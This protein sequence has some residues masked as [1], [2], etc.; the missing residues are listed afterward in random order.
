MTRKDFEEDA[1]KYL[2]PALRQYRHN[3]DVQTE[4]Q[5]VHGFEYEE[6]IKLMADLIEENERLNSLLQ[7]LHD[8]TERLIKALQD[9]VA[10][11]DRKHD[12][13]DAAKA[14]IAKALGEQ[15]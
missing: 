6:T 1:K 11:S 7:T 13:W 10:I 8:I 12:A 9:V 5:F 15:I 3:T 14:A 4:K 2:L